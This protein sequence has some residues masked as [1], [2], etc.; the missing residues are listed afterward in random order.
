MKRVLH[1]VSNMHRGGAET[2]IMNLYRNIDKSKIQFDFVCHSKKK[3]DY[4]D[5]IIALGGR[6]FRTESLGTV[7]FKKYVK[8]LKSIIKENG[9]FQAVHAHT[10][11]QAGV[12]TL[13]AKQAGVKVRVCHSHNTK[14]KEKPNIQ[15]NIQSYLLRNLS[16]YTS[17]RYCACGKEAARFFFGQSYLKKNKVKILNNGINIEEFT[18]VSKERVYITKKQLNIEEN[19][20]VLGHIGRFYEQKN[21]KFLVKIAN[22]LKNR[23][24]EFKMFLVGDGPLKEEIENEVIKNNLQNNIIFLGIRKDI[25][26]LMKIFNVFLFPSFYE[27]LPLTLIETQASGLPA[28]VSDAITKEVDLGLN[29]INYKSLN[30]SLDKWIDE[31]IKLKEC[32]RLNKKIINKTI[33]DMGYDAKENAINIQLLYNVQNKGD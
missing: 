25:P 6:I 26:V 32:K 2:M 20:L 15:D 23:N 1:V 4:D 30:D 11:I 28:I 14:W 5:E 27:G 3:A 8:N 13:A 7:G 17:N 21:H 22:E 18:S 10:D 33:A 16:K 24:I 9:P 12:V 31:I 29:I 19:I